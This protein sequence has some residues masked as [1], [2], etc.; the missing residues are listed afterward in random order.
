MLNHADRVHMESDEVVFDNDFNT[1]DRVNIAKIMITL[2]F[3]GTL[4]LP[5]INE[6]RDVQLAINMGLYL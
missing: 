3:H 6:T 5:M 1:V 2:D 4:R